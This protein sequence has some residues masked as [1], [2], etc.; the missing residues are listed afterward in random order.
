[1]SYISLKTNFIIEFGSLKLHTNNT[2]KD[3][4]FFG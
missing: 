3:S 4:N 2:F 1:M